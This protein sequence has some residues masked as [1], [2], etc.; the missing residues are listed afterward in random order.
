VGDKL[1]EPDFPGVLM[2]ATEINFYLAE[3]AARGYSVGN[4]AE[5]YYNAAIETSF[6]NW[7]LSSGDAAA[8]LANPAVAYATAAGDFKEKIGNQAWIAF[9]NRS[10]ESWTSWRRLDFPA[11]VV[12]P[13]A[14]PEAEGEIP[15]RY[16]YPII[17]QTVNAANWSAASDA[18][19]GDKLK[20]H[21]F[22]DAN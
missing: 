20:T 12:P 21:V 15:K 8:Y 1:K 11:I 16:T 10:F 3:A 13:S 18:I 7:G 2:E 14:Y 19:G 6:E 17:E 4:S 5:S 9:Y 22:W